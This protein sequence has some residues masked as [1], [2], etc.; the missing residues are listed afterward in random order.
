[1]SRHPLKIPRRLA[2]YSQ[3]RALAFDPE[4]RG[5]NIY[6][7]RPDATVNKITGFLTALP[8]R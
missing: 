3:G 4:E 2:C 6:V 5:G 1:M 8:A 7:D